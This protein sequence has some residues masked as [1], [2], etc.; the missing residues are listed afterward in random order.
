MS[1][2]GGGAARNRLEAG[3][4]ALGGIEEE[5]LLREHHASFELVDPVERDQVLRCRRLALQKMFEEFESPVCSHAT[6][7]T[8][9]QGRGRGHLGRK[10]HESE[11]DAR[12]EAP[13]RETHGGLVGRGVLERA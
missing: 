1:Q 13:H 7:A 12:V 10:S 6:V 8:V 4:G 3:Q 9:Q 5:S 11:R 2:S